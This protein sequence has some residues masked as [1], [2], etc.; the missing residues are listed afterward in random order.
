MGFLSALRSFL[1]DRSQAQ[2]PEDSL[3]RFRDAWGLDADAG[4]EA[5]AVPAPAAESR[6]APGPD[7]REAS[8][9]DRTQWRRKLHHIFEV[10]PAGSPEWPALLLEARALN[11]DDAWV[12]E[13]MREEFT[14][15]IR[16]HIADRRLT[17][18]ERAN[19]EAVRRR[20][21][22]TEQE[23]AAI[24]ES[25]VADARRFFGGDVVVES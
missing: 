20:I 7:A 24:V 1:A 14:M 10:D 23:A 18:D 25:V 2:A 22:W 16:S 9:Y 15:L 6:S 17:E 8:G 19:L 5:P 3:R 11:L 4:A 12:D 21:G 13:G